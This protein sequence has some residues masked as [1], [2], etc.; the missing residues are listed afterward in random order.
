MKGYELACL[1]PAV[2]ILALSGPIAAQE[3]RYDDHPG[4]AVVREQGGDAEALIR[5]LCDERSRPEAGFITEANRITRRETGR[6]NPASL[7]LRPWQDTDEVLI[8]TSWGVA[9]VPRPSSTGGVLSMEVEVGP[10]GFTR[11]DGQPVAVTYDM[12]KSGDLPDERTTVV[13]EANCEVR[14][15]EAPALRSLPG[16]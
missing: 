8:T 1:A 15:P 13:F 10:A 7:R 5:I 6:S 3:D 16:S 14:D 11:A 2:L 12:W 4:S 9:W